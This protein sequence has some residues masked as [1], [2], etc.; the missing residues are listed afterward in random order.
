M[1]TGGTPWLWKLT[2][3]NPWPLW[4]GNLQMKC[5]ETSVKPSKFHPPDSG[6]LEALPKRDAVGFQGPAE[7]A[8]HGGALLGAG[9]QRR[10][11]LRAKLPR[12]FRSILVVLLL[13]KVPK[14][15]DVKTA[16]WTAD[17]TD[18]TA[19]WR[20]ICH[21]HYHLRE[22]GQTLLELVLSSKSIPDLTIN[23]GN[24]QTTWLE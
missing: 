14:K 16:K 13:L 5:H 10:S 2:L 19:L 6:H 23:N 15:I 4:T 20:S 21:F 24:Q 1:I 12:F 11:T 7:D 22:L 18:R 8:A 17:R 9:H 3:W